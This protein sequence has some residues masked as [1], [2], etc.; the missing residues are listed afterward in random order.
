MRDGQPLFI[1]TAKIPFLIGELRLDGALRAAKESRHLGSGA[2][3]HAE[4]V[5][6]VQVTLFNTLQQAATAGSRIPQTD[7]GSGRLIMALTTFMEQVKAAGL[8]APGTWTFDGVGNIETGDPLPKGYYIYAAPVSTMT[9]ADRAA[10]K[11][12][13]ISILVCGAGAIQYAAPTI[14]FQR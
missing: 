2:A 7:E 5:N 10:R 12:P 6:G 11:A 9:S 3:E 13:P 1:G 8:C 14:I 4:L